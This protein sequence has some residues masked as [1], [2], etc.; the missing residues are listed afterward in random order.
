MLRLAHMGVPSYS[1]AFQTHDTPMDT[2]THDVV[3]HVASSNHYGINI[4]NY[5]VTYNHDH[6]YALYYVRMLTHEK[7][8]DLHSFH[9]HSCVPSAICAFQSE[10]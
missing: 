1:R 5:V 9:A 8:Y 6:S 7:T 2:Q 4:I 10:L 3:E